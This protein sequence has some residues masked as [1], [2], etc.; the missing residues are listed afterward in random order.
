MS[1]KKHDNTAVDLDK[2]YE[3]NEIQLKGIVYFAVGLVGLIVVTFALMYAF[4]NVLKDYNR[5]NAGPANPMIKSERERLP[6]EPRLQL[7][8]GFGVD[9]EHGRINMELG[10][11]QAEYRALHK[12]WLAL[13]EHGQKDEKTGTTTIMPIDEAK[14]KFLSQNAK[15][16]SGPA[17][18]EFFKN[19]HTY[20]SDAS[21]GRL[22]AEKRR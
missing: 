5:E 2:P 21:A 6:A 9:S 8:P 13:W 4:L 7:A 3:E 22:A 14:E 11:P 16:K 10:E 12:Q 20:I 19:S 18:E 15:A 17:A 1:S